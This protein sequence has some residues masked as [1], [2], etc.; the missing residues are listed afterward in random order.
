MNI[1]LVLQLLVDYYQATRGIGHTLTMVHGAG[2]TPGV[3]V[4][5]IGP[6]HGETLRDIDL[7]EEAQIVGLS[8]LAKLRD[9]T[10]APL[11][12]DN[13]A[14]CFL[15]DQA[16]TRIANLEAE[17]EKLHAALMRLL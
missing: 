5:A 12:F 9:C 10:P 16:A 7:L 13:G 11:A 2:N 4:V 17:N 3:A 15:F 1:K 8:D 6:R 14:L